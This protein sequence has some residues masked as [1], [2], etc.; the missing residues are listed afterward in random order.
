MGEPSI[1]IIGFG[2]VGQAI[3]HGFCHYTSVKVFDINKDTGFTYEEVINQDVLFLCLPTPMK[4]DGSVDLSIIGSATSKLSTSLP[5]LPYGDR[6]PVV[7]KSTMPPLACKYLQGKYGNLCIIFNPEFLTERTAKLDFIQQTRIILGTERKSELLNPP[8]LL[9]VRLFEHRFPGV[10]IKIVKW[11]EASM[12]KYGTNAFFCTKLSFF[13]ELH[14]IANALDL[15]GS[16]IVEEILNDGRIGRSHY[17][18]PGHDKKLG[19]G[20]SCFPKDINGFIEI[21]KRL[22]IDPIVAEAAW[23]KNLE[24]RPTLGEELQKL[25]GRAISDE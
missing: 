24:V 19:F 20:G 2:F 12:I 18:V 23:K 25:K 10:P 13:N 16:S 4:K 7:I 15:D 11:D 6:K 5:D 22:A 17:Q 9:V 1:G 21:A 8:T 3:S 14:Q